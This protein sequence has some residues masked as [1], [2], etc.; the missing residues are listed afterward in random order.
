MVI[1]HAVPAERYAVIAMAKIDAFQRPRPWIAYDV[2]DPYPGEKGG[3]VASGGIV[4][5]AE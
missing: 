3:V 1:L 5:D 4:A 2:L